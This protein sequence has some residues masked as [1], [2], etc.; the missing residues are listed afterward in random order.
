E[1][2]LREVVAGRDDLKAILPAWDRI[3]AAQKVIGEN[4]R[5][6]NLLEGGGAFHS[7]LFGI[8]RTL[9]RA[10]AERPKPNGERLREFGESA[11]ESLELQLLSEKPIYNDLE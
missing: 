10:A 1:K 6:Y 3:A 7:Q 4:A 5:A 9:L 2:Q 8:A 11:R